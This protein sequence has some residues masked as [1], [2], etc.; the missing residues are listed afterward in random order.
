MKKTI[1]YIVLCTLVLSLAGCGAKRSQAYYDKPSQLLSVNYD[2]TF[3]I[4]TQVR[5]RNASLIFDDAQRKAVEEVI[6]DGVK[7]ASS[8]VADLKP[9]CFD[10]N[11]REKYEDYF[12]IFFRDGGEW[13][14]YAGLKDKR[15]GSTR[16]ERTSSQTVGTVTVT[17]DRAALKTRLQADGIIPEEG[18]Y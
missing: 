11:A 15:S 16:Y 12:R 13:T 6:F 1:L 18:R 14:K 2:G 3:V 17:V 9:L 5:S 4:R 7:S 8:S 10:M